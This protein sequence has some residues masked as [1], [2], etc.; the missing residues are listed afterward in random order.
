[1]KLTNW[2]NIFKMLKIKILKHQQKIKKITLKYQNQFPMNKS[3]LK[4]QHQP[5]IN[6]HIKTTIL[7]KIISIQKNPRDFPKKKLTIYLIKFKFNYNDFFNISS[8]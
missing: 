5:M 6:K 1:M 4:K 3:Q 7:T 8:I 2:S